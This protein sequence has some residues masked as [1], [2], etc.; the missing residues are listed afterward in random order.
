MLQYMRAQAD[1]HDFQSYSFRIDPEVTWRQWNISYR[2]TFDYH[3]RMIEF[4]NQFLFNRLKIC[5]ED[6]I[7]A[8][9]IGISYLLPHKRKRYYQIMMRW[10]KIGCNRGY[11][12]G[13]LNKKCQGYKAKYYNTRKQCNKCRK[14]QNT[15][16]RHLVFR[17]DKKRTLEQTPDVDNGTVLQKLFKENET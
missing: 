7:T 12:N 2:Q 4:K 1:R 8:K 10:L 16:D 6:P 5:I 9:M 14:D 13:N 17:N 11:R 15:I 3:P